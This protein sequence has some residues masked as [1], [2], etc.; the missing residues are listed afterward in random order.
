MNEHRH[1][2]G[3]RN[4]PDPRVRK[5]PWAR[6]VHIAVAVLVA[7]GVVSLP[8]AA[9]AD[10]AGCSHT[11]YFWTEYYGA[12]YLLH[13]QGIGQCSLSAT[14]TLRVEM[15][16]DQW[17]SD[18]VISHYDDNWLGTYYVANTSTCDNGATHS[19]YARSYFTQDVQWVDDGYETYTSCS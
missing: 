6:L 19:Y 2:P 8:T 15:K 9:Y 10:P 18:I 4:D 14:R 17:P 7:G 11:A 13:G 1:I 12:G 16:S 3:P 5:S